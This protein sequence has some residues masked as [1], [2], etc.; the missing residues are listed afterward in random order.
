MAVIAESFLLEVGTWLS[1]RFVKHNEVFDLG[2]VEQRL[3][4]SAAQNLG[5]AQE[6]GSFGSY[7]VTLRLDDPGFFVVGET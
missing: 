5:N 6:F 1:K 2:Y 4:F 3:A 7:A